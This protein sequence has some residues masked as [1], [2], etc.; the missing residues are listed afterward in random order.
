MPYLS[1]SI[2]TQD[3]YKKTYTSKLLAHL[4]DWQMLSSHIEG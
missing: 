2:P 1:S 4:L 3:P